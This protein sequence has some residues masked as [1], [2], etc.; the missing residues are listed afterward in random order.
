M[1]R[2]SPGSRFKISRWE[3]EIS[4]NFVGWLKFST[5]GDRRIMLKLSMRSCNKNAERQRIPRSDFLWNLPSANPIIN[6]F[7]IQ[8]ERT[9]LETIL[10]TKV[11]RPHN[12]VA[13]RCFDLVMIGLLRDGDIQCL[14]HWLFHFQYRDFP[15]KS[16]MRFSIDLIVCN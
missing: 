13:V 7:M 10:E 16:M 9:Y 8:L 12:D 11:D 4:C 3:R 14:R 1:P 2:I 6:N 15:R 5:K